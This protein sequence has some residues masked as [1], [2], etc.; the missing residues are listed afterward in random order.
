MTLDLLKDLHYYIVDLDVAEPDV[1]LT[2]GLAAA[3]VL[4]PSRSHDR[5]S[6][7]PLWHDRNT[8]QRVHMKRHTF[9]LLTKYALL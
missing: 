2:K 8:T 1:L 5:G 6:D 3:L 7:E 9:S 4:R